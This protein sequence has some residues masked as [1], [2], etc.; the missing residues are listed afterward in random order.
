M[1]NTVSLFFSWMAEVFV[2]ID[3]RVAPEDTLEARVYHA[4]VI[5]AALA[6][7]EPAFLQQEITTTE[8]RNA[9]ETA[10][11]ILAS[12]HRAQELS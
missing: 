5:G 2:G 9:F 1:S 4:L 11:I 10:Q 8:A 3:D 6:L 12:W 7:L